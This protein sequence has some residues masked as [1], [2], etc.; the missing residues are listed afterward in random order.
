LYALGNSIE[1]RGLYSVYKVYAVK[2]L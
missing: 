1:D 2:R